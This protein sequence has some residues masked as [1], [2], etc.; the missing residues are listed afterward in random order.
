M[1][2]DSE[3]VIGRGVPVTICHLKLDLKVHLRLEDGDGGWDAHN[4][5]F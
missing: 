2:N 4:W 1:V 3:Q 5:M